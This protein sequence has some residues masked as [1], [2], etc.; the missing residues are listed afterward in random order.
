M[1]IYH[2]KDHSYPNFGTLSGDEV[3]L[4]V[5]DHAYFETRR[6]AEILAAMPSGTT[7]YTSAYS[8]IPDPVSERMT[9]EIEAQSVASPGAY[10]D[11]DPGRLCAVVHRFSPPM[12]TATERTL[13]FLR[14]PH[15][16]Q[17]PSGLSLGGKRVSD[18][19]LLYT[20]PRLALGAL[21]GPLEAKEAAYRIA[22]LRAEVN[23]MVR[24]R[25]SA[26]R[27]PFLPSVGNAAV[28][29]VLVSP[30]AARDGATHRLLRFSYNR[31][32]FSAF[33]YAWFSGQL[34]HCPCENE[35]IQAVYEEVI[36]A[37]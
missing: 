19:S 12:G 16:A 4:L 34:S 10:A 3:Y 8:L 36:S 32:R 26:L 27:I 17:L 1:D 18:A 14:C 23:K 24:G 9:I 33:V 13:V 30:E 28:A 6:R 21:D 35:K 22:M 11:T 7:V 25:C 29:A 37:V 5:G 31:E 2:V 15:L 20:R